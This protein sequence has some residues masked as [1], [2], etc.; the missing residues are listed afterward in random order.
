M[1]AYPGTDSYRGNSPRV[2]VVVAMAMDEP[3]DGDHGAPGHPWLLLSASARGDAFRGG[4]GGPLESRTRA[5]VGK[6]RHVDPGRFRRA[7]CGDRLMNGKLKAVLLLGVMYG[8]GA[9]SG[10]AWQRYRFHHYWNPHTMFAERRI[11]RLTS[12]LKLSPEQEQSVRGIIQ[13][14]HER[15][16][17]V[18]EEVSW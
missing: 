4:P 2:L 5:A 10:V 9:V 13:K 17:Q 8:L 7:F 11:K 3:S 1:D 12:Q 16:V 15:A 6:R 14:A 18:N